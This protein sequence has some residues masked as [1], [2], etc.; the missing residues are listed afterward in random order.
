[1]KQHF[2]SRTSLFTIKQL[3]ALLLVCGS[4]F[5]YSQQ[6]FYNRQENFLKANS[7]WVGGYK[8]GINFNSG[9]AVAIQ[10]EIEGFEGC[11]S[12]ADPVTGQL[13]FYTDGYKCWDRN[14]QVMPNGDSLL[15][16]GT[17]RTTTQGA[18]I[19]PVIDSVGKY[20]LFS[21]NHEGNQ[22]SLYYS[23]V[24]MSLN[25]GLGD[26]V[27]GRKN[28]VLDNVPLSESMIAIPGNNCDIWLLVHE[29][30]QP[31]FKAYHITAAGLDTIPV[32]STA[33][34]AIQGLS[35]YKTGCSAVSPDRSRIAI[36]SS[37]GFFNTIPN[38]SGVLVGKFNAST[39]QVSDAI[40]LSWSSTYGVAFSPDNSKLYTAGLATDDQ[41][42][43]QYDVSVF[44]S[45]TIVSSR[46]V[47]L[48][49]LWAYF[50][51]GFYLSKVPTYLRL[52]GDKIY[53]ILGL[54]GGL[55]LACINNPNAAG[56]AVTYDSALVSLPGTS[57]W[58]LMNH[59]VANEVVYPLYADT[60]H[61][62]L[63]DTALCEGKEI[64]LAGA[65]DYSGYLWDNGSTA[66]HRTVTTAGTYW[67]LNQGACHSS[68][69]TFIVNIFE[70]PPP[71]VTVDEFTLST[72]SPYASYQW[73]LDGQI[74]PG[75]TGA[76]YVVT[77]NGD[78]QV[79]VSNDQ[80]CEATSA[81][82]K[83]TNVSVDYVKSLAGKVRI[84]PNPTNTA[85]YITA[86]IA[87]K[88]YLVSIEGK[89]LKFQD[90]TNRFSL[91]DVAEGIYFLHIYDQDNR[92][93]KTEKIVKTL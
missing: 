2:T 57:G 83:I 73:L 10:T 76:T 41:G 11:A 9:N 91:Q 16:N 47:I 54:D 58:E 87:V 74:I 25:A 1:M 14:N 3:L 81:V 63:L 53:F 60:I 55:S 72:T 50:G 8:S 89:I 46:K 80:G 48:D 20:Y 65:A 22:P 24:D 62:L 43:S 79:I 29:A 68:L 37:D 52:Y 64:I 5:S 71:V 21:L 84:Y 42:I 12:V 82:Y 31:V 35:A 34:T 56:N 75:A 70:L 44:D 30:P 13:L 85:V 92:L 18:C 39:G 15:D 36:G 40:P 33:G 28:I 7:I 77:K 49:T 78:Y 66:Q 6:A 51:F 67:V 32:T 61:Q 88:L 19:V 23:I 17:F 26:V 93:L 86:P 4:I 27:P 45:A 69:D 90:D 38:A 59:A